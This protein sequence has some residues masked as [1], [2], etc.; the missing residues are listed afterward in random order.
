M[1]VYPNCCKRV[2]GINREL[3]SFSDRYIITDRTIGSGAFAT[4]RL[5]T[6]VQTGKQ[7][8]CKIHDLDRLR[9]LADTEDLVRRAFD[10]TDLLGKLRHPNLPT[11]EYAFRSAHT[12]YTLY[13]DTE[14]ATGGDLFSMRVSRGTLDEQEC[15]FIIGQIVNAIRYL[16]KGDI[17]HRDLK[18][19]NVFFATGPDLRSRVIVGDLGFARS[20]VLGRMASRVEYG[21]E[22]GKAV[23]LWSLGMITVF[24]LAPDSVAAGSFVKTSQAAINEWMNSVLSDLSHHEISEHCQDFIKSCLMFEPKRRIDV[25]EA[26][27]HPWLQRYPDK[28]QFKFRITESI[29]AWKKTARTIAPPVQELPDMEN[30]KPAQP[31]KQGSITHLSTSIKSRKR[32]LADITLGTSIPKKSP[33]FSGKPAVSKRLKSIAADNEGRI[34]RAVSEPTEYFLEYRAEQSRKDLN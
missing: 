29:E 12:L 18:P 17:V 4:V 1:S 34:S 32:K 22:H 5:A 10:E 9:R 27:R 30:V 31:I 33:Y 19:E 20:T 6:N 28:K 7:L 24:L 13:V 14:L 11:L 25:V 3:Q 15:K 16:H 23:D 26:K 8:A 2:D 21:Q